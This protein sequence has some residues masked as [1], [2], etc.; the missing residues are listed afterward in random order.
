V[1]QLPNQTATKEKVTPLIGIADE[2]YVEIITLFAYVL[3]S[4]KNKINSTDP[5]KLSRWV[6]DVFSH[7][8]TISN[9]INSLNIK[10]WPKMQ[11]ILYEKKITELVVECLYLIVEKRI[12]SN[13]DRGY[14]SSIDL[15]LLNVKVMLFRALFHCL[16][17]V[18]SLKDINSQ[19]LH[20]QTAEKIIRLI[21]AINDNDKLYNPEY[22]L[23]NVDNA[24]K[25][26]NPNTKAL[27]VLYKNL[28][29]YY[30]RYK[31]KLPDYKSEF[32][33]VSRK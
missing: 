2:E 23:K 26:E 28:I 25:V 31:N 30:Q 19:T 16:A 11:Q 4:L 21:G 9:L 3:Q 17:M 12:F 32:I 24:R 20:P 10:P 33:A 27:G 1:N 14:E 22:I 13:F 29:D 6:Y 7:I 5:Q 8:Y 18:K 15:N